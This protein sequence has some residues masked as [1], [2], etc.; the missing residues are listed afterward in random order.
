M[1]HQW[2]GRW[3]A[4]AE[5]PHTDKSAPAYRLRRI[6]TLENITGKT[7]HLY[8]ASGGYQILYI[9]GQRP[10]DRVLAPAPCQYDKHTFYIVYDVS[11][12]LHDGENTIEVELGNGW[13]DCG[14]ATQWRN[15]HTPW[16]D[17]VKLCCDLEIDG[18]VI[19]YSNENWQWC[20]TPVTFNELRNGE[21]YDARLE[22]VPAVY[23]TVEIVPPPGGELVEETAPPCRVIE[24]IDP[25][26]E[27]LQL[28]SFAQVYDFG[29]NISGVCCL[30]LS[31]PAGAQ[32]EIEYAE[33]IKDNGDIDNSY[34]SRFVKSGSFQLDRYTLKGGSTEIFQPR[35]TYHGF[36][37]MLIKCFDENVKFH[38]VQAALIHTD[39]RSIGSIASDN[40]TLNTLQTMTRRSFLTNFVGI[41]TD[42]PHREKNG[43]TGDAL[44]A[45]ECG[46][47]NFD[48]R[49]AFS[50]FMQT[51]LD[52]QRPSGQLAA[53]APTGVFGYNNWS[54]PGW[55]SVIFEYASKV[56][57][58]CG[59]D[60]LIKKH[61][62][63]LKRYTDYCRCMSD[64]DGLVGFGLGDWC[65]PEYLK[66]KTIKLTS[67]AFYCNDLKLLSKFAAI[68]GVDGTEF[69][70]RAEAVQTAIWQKFAADGKW[71]DLDITAAAGLL[72]FDLAPQEFK[73]PLVQKIV[74][75]IRQ[76]AHRSYFGMFGAKWI[77]RV[78]ADHGYADD[79]IKLFTQ[80]ECP[81]W[82]Y[83]VKKGE[84]TLCECWNRMHS[85]NHVL[86]GDISAW[87]FEYLGGVA[88]RW[89]EPGFK[90]FDYAPVFPAGV[91]KF[92]MSYRSV[93][94]MIESSWEKSGSK[95]IL[96]LQVPENCRAA[97]NLPGLRRS[98]NGGKHQFT[99]T[100]M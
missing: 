10:D 16:R 69:A 27:P 63:A 25:V 61:F 58:Y 92:Q 17:R 97:V 64:A 31:G 91:N 72:Y 41:P 2:Q 82:G 20:F 39:L 66:L 84:S 3:I 21:F 22:D 99:V 38:K 36:R 80:T 11:C 46:L 55:D 74:D 88:P 54:G 60:E 47:W 86:F 51:V 50:D 7:A 6:F 87:M 28:I 37:Y 40:A 8:L 33:S 45:A 19:L 83:W 75:F 48:C 53:V 65:N 90:R 26:A 98:V 42:C 93:N 34:F 14:T 13:Y 1:S 23:N 52:T 95:V 4:P 96:S 94:G 79:V 43:W 29:R 9:N 77:P 18:N 70:Q 68:A 89:D 62:N 44:T 85:R 56:Y 24:Y 78:L 73:L 59:C 57:C 67:S 32:V 15:E 81:G 5:Q 49:N 100:L 35:F 30:E 71:Q 76:N 12:L